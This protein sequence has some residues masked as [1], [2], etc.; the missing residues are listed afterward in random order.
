MIG[1]IPYCRQARA[2]RIE[3]DKPSRSVSAS[4][5]DSNCAAR[6]TRSRGW[7]VP[8]LSEKALDE[9]RYQDLAFHTDD[10]WWY[11]HARAKGTLIRR[12]PGERKLEFIEN[13]QEEGLWN[14]GNKERNDIN[15]RKLISYYGDPQ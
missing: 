3:P 14:T 4:A 8:Y 6:S 11:F 1:A 2:K 9:N 15:L 5:G 12:I 7:V 10:L 13:T